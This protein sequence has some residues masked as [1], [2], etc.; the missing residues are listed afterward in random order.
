V[1][2]PNDSDHRAATS[3][4]PLRSA[5]I[6]RFGASRGSRRIKFRVDGLRILPTVEHRDNVHNVTVDKIV[7]GKGERF[8]KCPMESAIFLVDTRIQA[9]RFNIDGQGV[10]KVNPQTIALGFV[11]SAPASRSRSAAGNSLILI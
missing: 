6:R 11:K 5:P 1:G 8:R 7:N 10:M 4:L 2:W 9:E 3:D